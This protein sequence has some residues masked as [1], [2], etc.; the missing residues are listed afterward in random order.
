MNK[1]RDS[2]RRQPRG[3]PRAERFDRPG[4]I[5]ATV[6]AGRR[7]VCLLGGLGRHD[8]L[9]RIGRLGRRLGR[10]RA[11]LRRLVHLADVLHE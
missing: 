6:A 9:R 1:L 4:S 5:A 11:G 3:D 10:R 2:G 7:W 8:A